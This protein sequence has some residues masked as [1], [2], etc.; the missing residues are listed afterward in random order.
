MVALFVIKC[1]KTLMSPSD[2][3]VYQFNVVNWSFCYYNFLFR[4]YLSAYSVTALYF[5]LFQK[6][7]NRFQF[8][9]QSFIMFLA[10]PK[11]KYWVKIWFTFLVVQSEFI[12]YCFKKCHCLVALRIQISV[13]SFSKSYVSRKLHWQE[14][15]EMTQGIEPH[16]HCAMFSVVTHF[17]VTQLE[18][19]MKQLFKRDL[20]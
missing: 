2:E 5:N 10:H 12:Y 1:R 14:P 3:T 6:Y 7:W 17:S 9:V 4:L 20:G 11:L 19:K 15:A 16:A 8:F 13:A 18:A